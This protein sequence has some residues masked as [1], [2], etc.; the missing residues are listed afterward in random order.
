MIGKVKI[1][2]K[3]KAAENRKSGPMNEKVVITT[4]CSLLYCLCPTNQE[5]VILWSLG[6]DKL[7]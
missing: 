4:P 1:G 5:I 3:L 2:V 7:S 6:T